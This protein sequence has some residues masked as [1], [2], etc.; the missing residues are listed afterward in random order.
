MMHEALMALIVEKGYESVTVQ[1]I[2]D[3]ADLGRSTFYSHY[4]SKDELLLSGFDRL[5]AAIEEQY[6]RLMTA[7]KGGNGIGF[8]VSL[9][10]F[11]H[12]EQNLPLY[13]AIVGKESG[14]MIMRY[15]HRFLCDLVKGHLAEVVKNRKTP[16]RADAAAHWFVSSFLSLLT[17]WLDNKLPVTAE[18]ID[19]MFRK[20][21]MPGLEA[22]L[23]IKAF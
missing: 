3:R 15:T 11:R 23:G 8:N 9:E 16:V 7:K 4:R 21:T 10:L 14:Q 13:K 17:W 22:S 6:Q 12:A 1:D 18:K 2:L 19:E 5:R 20:L